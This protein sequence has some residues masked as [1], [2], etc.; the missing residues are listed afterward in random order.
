MGKAEVEKMECFNAWMTEFAPNGIKLEW[1]EQQGFHC[2]LVK[3]CL[4]GEL[5]FVVPRKLLMTREAAY[6]S[7]SFG[8]LAGKVEERLEQHEA[9]SETLQEELVLLLFL[10]HEK[11]ARK[12]SRWWRYIQILPE[13]FPTPLFWNEEDLERSL[14]GTPLYGLVGETRLEL[15]NAWI[16]CEKLLRDHFGE[17]K[18]YSLDLFLWAYSVVQS[19]AYRVR[20]ADGT[21]MTA[22]VPMADFSNHVSDGKMAMI[23]EMHKIDPQ[24]DCLT[25][26]C[27]S[28]RAFAAGDELTMHY[29]DLANWQLFMHYGFVLQDNPFDRLNIALDPESLVDQDDEELQIRKELL[30]QFGADYGLGLDHSLSHEVPK[31]LLATLRLL[32]ATRADLEGITIDNLEDRLVESELSLENEQRCRDCLGGILNQL[33]CGGHS[34]EDKLARLYRKEHDNIVDRLIASIHE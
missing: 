9:C 2:R 3:D 18:G 15:E 17:L 13:S 8:S 19:R 7:G 31:E 30:L 27:N 28:D 33:R 4:P 29:N 11:I 22:L 5:L 6:A 25:A 23:R 26:F 16:W 10:M 34:V 14:T 32:L 1:S 24:L 21:L 20:M 12:E